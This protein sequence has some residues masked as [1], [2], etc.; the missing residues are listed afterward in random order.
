MQ[1]W[2][3]TGKI[4]AV[5]MSYAETISPYTTSKLR[6]AVLDAE[7]K[8][9]K[10][11]HKAVEAAFQVW[12]KLPFLPK[13]IITSTTPLSPKEIARWMIDKGL[14]PSSEEENGEDLAHLYG[15]DIALTGRGVAGIARIENVDANSQYKRERVCHAL[16]RVKRARNVINSLL[17]C[18]DLGHKTI[19]GGDIHW[20]LETMQDYMN[21]ACITGNREEALRVADNAI[22]VAYEFLAH[23][24][25]EY[26]QLV[27]GVWSALGVI[28]GRRANI[29][30]SV[31]DLRQALHYV[32]EA[33][34]RQPNPHRLA[35]VATWA[36]IRP[37]TSQYS[38][39]PIFERL[40]CSV[41]GLSK[42]IKA[43]TRNPRSS[44]LAVW[45]F[46]TG[47]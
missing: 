35:T 5:A 9:Q 36:L 20:P 42:L 28:F 40:L 38:A 41:E 31:P 10:C 34:E 7:Q 29:T 37:W 46:A 43:S 1:I 11:D 32:A 30:G 45:Q 21:T 13:E 26:P 33:D 16:E 2:H 4:R 19:D 14:L 3:F 22:Q 44:L 8:R 39:E 24:S 12:G 27:V 17:R 23:H 15:T 6:D 18:V 25:N 47:G